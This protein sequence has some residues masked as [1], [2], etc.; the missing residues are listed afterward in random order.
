MY[1]Y[2]NRIYDMF[3]SRHR[4][5]IAYLFMVKNKEFWLTMLYI[6]ITVVNLGYLTRAHTYKLS[7]N[8]T[9]A[10][11]PSFFSP[12]SPHITRKITHDG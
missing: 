8:R 3:N 6:S 4:L 10:A 9:E 11:L 1:A 12:K 5:T 7:I 2:D